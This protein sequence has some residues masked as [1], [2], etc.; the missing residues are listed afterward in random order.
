[1]QGIGKSSHPSKETQKIAG[2]G[3]VG[4]DNQPLFA[5]TT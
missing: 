4:D 1:M 3:R 2:I 5:N